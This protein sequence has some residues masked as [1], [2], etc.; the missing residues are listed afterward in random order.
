MR[1]VGVNNVWRVGLVRVATLCATAALVPVPGLVAQ[2][3]AIVELPV[4]PGP[5]LP[6]ISYAVTGDAGGGAAEIL[7]DTRGVNFQPYIKQILQEIYTQWTHLLPDEAH[8]PTLAKGE[9]DIRFKILP[10]GQIGAM[11]LDGNTHDESLNKAAWGAVAEVKQFPPLPATF[12][13]PH[14]ELRVRFRVNLPTE[15]VR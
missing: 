6:A 9:T 1:F 12:T 10:D 5:R 8:P 2:S 13:G 14:L 15:S 3:R 7:S 4:T 11:L